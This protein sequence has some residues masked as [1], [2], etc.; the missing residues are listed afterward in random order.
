MRHAPP[1]RRHAALVAAIA[2]IALLLTPGVAQGAA[3]ANQNDSGPGSLRQAVIDAAPGETIVLPAGTYSLTSGPLKVDKSLAL[4]G[5][6]PGDTTIRSGAPF[7]VIETKGKVD[8]TISGVTIRDGMVLSGVAQGAGIHADEGSLALR[9]AAVIDNVASSA[10]TGPGGMG[11]ISQGGGIYAGGRLTLTDTT[12]ADNEALAQ[13]NAEKLGGIAQGGGIFAKGEE[14][15]AGVMTISGATIRANSV[16]ASGGDGPGTAPAGIAQGGGIYAE[17]AKSASSPTSIVASTISENAVE[18]T[19]G[20]GGSNGIVNGGGVFDASNSGSVSFLNVTVAANVARAAEPA[21]GIVRGG[22]LYLSALPPGTVAI[23]S[24]TIV[25]NS[26]ETP[27]SSALGGNVYGA[28]DPA[29]RTI[30]SSIVA[31]GLGAAATEN[32]S[33]QALTSLGFNLESSDQ[34]AF[35]AGGDQVNRGPQLGP[36]QSNG[37]PT[38]TMAPAPGSP[39]VD[40][41]KSFDLTADQRGLLRP[42][43]L[44]AV[45]NS[46][47]AGADGADVGAVELQLPRAEEAVALDNSI[48]LGKLRRNRRKGT[49]TL[50][51]FLPRPSAGTLALQGPKLQPQSFSIN[52]ESQVKLPIVGKKD[53]RKALRRRGRRKVRLVVLYTPPG[54]ATGVRSRSVKLIKKLPR[55]RRSAGR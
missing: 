37:G 22:G 10:G 52:G 16:D 34:C 55:Q 2:S 17:Q 45:P 24:A 33:E 51:V 32:C 18:A 46:T 42:V 40:Q 25:G 11:G 43:E 41:G 6:G 29:L 9:E 4:S 48:L 54:T 23:R 39:A 36:L 7:R 38:P 28:G 49:A 44:P 8:L 1:V 31:D 47:A 50:A 27:S 15:D 14:I 21:G 26:T 30:A 12:V 5:H 35:H 3:V 20:P 53:V 19:G 13:G